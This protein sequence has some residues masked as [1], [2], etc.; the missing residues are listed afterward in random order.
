MSWV[1]IYRFHHPV[2]AELVKSYLEAYGIETY[3]LQEGAARAIGVYLGPFGEI[4]LLVPEQQRNEAQVLLREFL[5]RA[6]GEAPPPEDEGPPSM[7][8]PL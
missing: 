4:R 5:R 1:E 3:L 8:Q 2:E 6:R 7:P